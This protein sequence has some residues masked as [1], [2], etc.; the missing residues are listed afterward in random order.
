MP[1]L[2]Y[3]LAQMCMQHTSLAG[4]APMACTRNA[5]TQRESSAPPGHGHPVRLRGFVGQKEWAWLVPRNVHG[6]SVSGV[7]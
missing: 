2:R 1:V 6:T 4:A 7:A 5:C 3:E